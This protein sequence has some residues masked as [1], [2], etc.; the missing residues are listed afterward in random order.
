[1]FTSCSHYIYI[2]KKFD[3]QTNKRKPNGIQKKNYLDFNKSFYSK[4]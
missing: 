1:M 4:N 2:I 3:I